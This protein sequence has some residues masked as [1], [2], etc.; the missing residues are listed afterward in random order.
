MTSVPYSRYVVYPIPWYSFLIVLG[1]AAAIILAHRESIRS[2]LG[3]DTI[4]DLAL[5]LI[6]IGIIGA[7]LYYVVFS[8]SSFRHDLL[9]VFRIWEGGLAIYGAVIAGLIVLLVFSRRRRIPSLLL[10]DII[11]PGLVLAQGI[12]RWGNY[13]NMEAYGLQVSNPSLCFF[14][15]AVEIPSAAGLSWHLATFFYESVWDLGVF[16]FLI[17]ARHTRLRRQGDVFFFYAFLYASGRLVIEDLRLDSLY[18]FSSVRI[19][20]LISVLVCIVLLSRYIADALKENRLGIL[21]KFLL[22]P[23][24]AAVSVLTLLY[25]ATGTVSVF[26]SVFHRTAFLSGSSLLMIICLFIVYFSRSKEGSHADDEA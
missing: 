20:Q 9:S 12:G 23:L 26:R 11:S 24:T 5:W 14:P 17:S 7:R 2:G 19:S 25:A 8:W 13:F 6:P 15:L 22:V 10:C 3:K 4:V 21:V 1:A 18:S 16:V